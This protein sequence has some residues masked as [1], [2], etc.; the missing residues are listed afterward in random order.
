MAT[1]PSAFDTPLT[2]DARVELP[3]IGG[4][5]YPC[6]NPELVAAVS[7]A[8]GLGVIQPV[9]LTFVHGW[10]FRDGIRYIRSLTGKPIGMNALIE[11]SSRSYRRRVEGWISTALEEGVRFF[12]TSLG[13]PEW[14]VDRVHAAGGVVYHDV[15]ERRW[16]LKALDS[17]V[18]GLIGVND[19]AGGHSG[20]RS[21]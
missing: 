16:A 15:T 19:L 9:S 2:R 11:G 20:P 18:D 12:V 8:G 4:P 13:K 10:D 5:M 3:V 6:S 17:G 7:E 21:P 1:P 14:V